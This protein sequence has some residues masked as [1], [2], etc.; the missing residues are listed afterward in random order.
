[1]FYFLKGQ[2]AKDKFDNGRNPKKER[3]SLTR[4]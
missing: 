4:L 3:K 1:M 2:T